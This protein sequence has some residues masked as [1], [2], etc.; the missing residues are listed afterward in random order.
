MIKKTLKRMPKKR[1]LK[2]RLPKQSLQ[3]QQQKLPNLL[4]KPPNLQLLHLQLQK[5]KLLPHLLQLQLPQLLQNLNLLQNLKL[6]KLLLMKMMLE[7]NLLPMKEMKEVWTWKWS[8]RPN[9][10]ED[11]K[12]QQFAACFNP[13]FK[14][15]NDYVRNCQNCVK[16]YV[17]AR[18]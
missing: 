12:S 11:L 8:N 15:L 14:F 4:L 10:V 9:V 1:S 13:N 18:L 5:L 6:K 3:K 7:M 2:K 17:F 16:I